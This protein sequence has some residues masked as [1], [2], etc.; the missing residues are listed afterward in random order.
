MNR[1]FHSCLPLSFFFSSLCHY[2]ISFFFSETFGSELFGFGFSHNQLRSTEISRMVWWLCLLFFVQTWSSGVPE[3]VLHILLQEA[4]YI[5]SRGRLEIIF[6]HAL[7]TVPELSGMMKTLKEVG[8]FDTDLAALHSLYIDNHVNITRL[9]DSDLAQF[10]S[11]SLWYFDYQARQ[12]TELFR[13]YLEKWQSLCMYPY[14]PSFLR[15]NYPYFFEGQALVFKTTAPADLAAVEA[16]TMVLEPG[17]E[18][19]AVYSFL[20]AETTYSVDHLIPGELV[21]LRYSAFDRYAIR[22]ADLTRGCSVHSSR[23][24]KLLPNQRVAV[25]ILEDR[26]HVWQGGQLLGVAIPVP[27]AS[28]R[29]ISI[30]A[31]SNDDGFY[32]LIINPD[33]VKFQVYSS[34][35]LTLPV[36]DDTF[37][38]GN[39]P[40]IVGDTVKLERATLGF[41]TLPLAGDKDTITVEATQYYRS[42]NARITY[43]PEGTVVAKLKEP[44]ILYSC[45]SSI[46]GSDLLPLYNFYYYKSPLHRA[47]PSLL[48]PG[49]VPRQPVN[50]L[51]MALLDAER[52]RITRLIREKCDSLMFGAFKDLLEKLCDELDDWD[53]IQSLLPLD[54]RSDEGVRSFLDSLD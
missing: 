33:T 16:H 1:C 26:L 21:G 44:S 54:C 34:F 31:N 13:R 47:I 4:D 15:R 48:P 3:G 39:H 29:S 32:I 20:E 46:P 10:L 50:V 49:T 5:G 45:S 35:N 43:G 6:N 17:V 7:V 23:D 9:Y 19:K 42:A 25:Q 30:K 27:S 41:V 40:V 11:S 51:H 38:L 8:Q 37:D 24:V 28:R 22:Y 14:L 53:L 2:S 12:L 36:V 52:W 18:L